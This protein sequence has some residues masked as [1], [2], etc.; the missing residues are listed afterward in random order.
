[1]V[2]MVEDTVH[3]AL[4]LAADRPIRCSRADDHSEAVQGF[5]TR[6]QSGPQGPEA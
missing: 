5:M 2:G 4:A 3:S 6:T 1:M